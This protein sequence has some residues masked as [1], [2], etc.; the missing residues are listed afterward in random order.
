MGEFQNYIDKGGV[1]F[2]ILLVMSAIGTTIILYKF[3]E[4]YLFDNDKFHNCDELLD[5][6]KNISD[7]KEHLTGL[8]KSNFLSKHKFHLR[9]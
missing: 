6:S 5:Q 1:I 8:E 9:K 3:L 7:F 2:T 4:L